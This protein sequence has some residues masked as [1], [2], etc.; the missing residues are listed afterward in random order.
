MATEAAPSLR[1]KAKQATEEPRREP[2]AR[3]AQI[4][5]IAARVFRQKGYH[6]ASL[7]EVAKELNITRPAIY[8]YVESK[9]EILCEIY[10]Q[11]MNTLSADLATVAKSNL[12]PDERLYQMISYQVAHVIDRQDRVAIFFQE[13][14]QLQEKYSLRLRNK[15]REFERL[16]EGVIKEGIEQGIF[17]EVNPTLA[18]YAIL[19]MCNWVYQWYNPNGRLSPQQVGETFARLMSQGYLVR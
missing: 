16:F 11:V 1:T 3:R 6:A 18:T 10:E 4:I 19:G 14:A 8:H 5:E 2:G 9:E 17:S 12:P 13:S 15:R 7:E